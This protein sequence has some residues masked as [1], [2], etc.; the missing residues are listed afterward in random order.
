MSHASS[1]AGLT[2]AAMDILPAV[3][4]EPPRILRPAELA[5]VA[6]HA[7]PEPARAERPLPTAKVLQ[8]RGGEKP[9]VCVGLEL[10]CT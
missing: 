5:A 1:R 2:G 10:Q 8:E 3:P 9:R 4:A 7:Q 6:A